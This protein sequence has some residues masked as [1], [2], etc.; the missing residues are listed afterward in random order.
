MEV[1]SEQEY[2]KYIPFRC[3]IDDGYRQKLIKPVSEDGHRKTLQDLINEMFP[4]K[5]SN[6]YILNHLFNLIYYHFQLA[7]KHME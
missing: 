1:S 6:F 7:L 4:G 3:Y 2:F 5:D